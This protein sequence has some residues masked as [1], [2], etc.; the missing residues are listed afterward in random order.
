MSAAAVT[1]G[2]IT[3]NNVNLEHISA[4]SGVFAECGCEITGE[5]DE[6]SISAPQRLKSVKRVVTGV[7]PGFPTD[8]GPLLVGALSSADGRSV[9][10]ERIF[11]NRYVF[12]GELKK[13]GADIRVSGPVA[14]VNGTDK[15]RGA[16]CACTDLRGGAALIIAA[17]RAKGETRIGNICHIKRGYEQI[18]DNL[19]RLGA[20]I[21]ET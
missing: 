9:F 6:F 18:A 2:R 17:L 5:N 10:Y 14:V 8:A 19:K 21:I 3:F 7:Y 15:L 13:L 16:Q 4:I 1:G 12:A 20:D 11:K